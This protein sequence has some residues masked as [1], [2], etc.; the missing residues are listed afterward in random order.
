M[1]ILRE[2]KFRAWHKEA[3]EMLTVRDINFCAEEIC[4]YEMQGDWLSFDDVELMQYTGLTDSKGNEVYEGDVVQFYRHDDDTNRHVKRFISKI[5][6]S[7]ASFC[8]DTEYVKGRTFG[9]LARPGESYEVIG[10][11][12]EEVAHE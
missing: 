1:G 10:N 2:I 9:G 4:S 12:Y 3:E 5:Y 7:F 11:I 6:Y 8:F